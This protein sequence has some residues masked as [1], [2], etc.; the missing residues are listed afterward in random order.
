MYVSVNY[1]LFKCTPACNYYLFKCTPACNYCTSL[2]YRAIVCTGNEAVNVGV[3]SNCVHNPG[4]LFLK[5]RPCNAVMQ[6]IFTL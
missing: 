5:W 1:Y 4:G 3:H 6:V 2:Y